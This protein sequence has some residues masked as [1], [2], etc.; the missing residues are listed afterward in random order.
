MRI[1]T[2]FT[3]QNK[4]NRSERVRERGFDSGNGMKNDKEKTNDQGLE[5]EDQLSKLCSAY[6]DRELGDADQAP[7]LAEMRAGNA[8]VAAELAQLEFQTVCVRDYVGACAEPLAT[9][10]IWSA[11]AGEIQADCVRKAAE[12]EAAPREAAAATGGRIKELLAQL[13][14]SLKG[15]RTLVP[16]GAA[17]CAVLALTMLRSGTPGFTPNAAPGSAPGLAQ[18]TVTQNSASSSQA[19]IAGAA[20]SGETAV[21]VASGNSQDLGLTKPASQQHVADV[22]FVGLGRV[23]AASARDEEF[24]G[25]ITGVPFE[26]LDEDAAETI[27]SSSPKNELR[28]SAYAGMGETRM[29]V[30]TKPSAAGGAPQY[31]GTH[32]NVLRAGGVD[33]DFARGAGPIRIMPVQRRARPPVIW[34]SRLSG[35][36]YSAGNSGGDTGAAQSTGSFRSAA[37]ALNNSASGSLA[38]GA[39]SDPNG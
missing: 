4:R 14:E 34:V 24:P 33:I 22:T 31:I 7:L 17:A 13:G 36:N 37:S 10:D 20:A 32:R 23:A 1:V 26:L 21:Q 30:F 6:H 39:S 16:I 2:R 28:D 3:Q 9:V 15:R 29:S 5:L 25:Q 35:S 8:E 18:N 19:S 12:A 38:P 11:I 27:S